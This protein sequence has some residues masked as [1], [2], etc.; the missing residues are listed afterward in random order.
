MFCQVW[1]LLCHEFLE[2]CLVNLSTDQLLG[3]VVDGHHHV[4]YVDQ[5]PEGVLLIEKE[6]GNS[7]DAIKSLKRIEIFF[8][9]TRRLIY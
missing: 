6:Q 4:H 2:D 8:V 7:S 1:Q 5:Q 9:L 3:V